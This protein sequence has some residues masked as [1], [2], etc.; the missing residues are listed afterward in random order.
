M[1]KDQ[2]AHMLAKF[3]YTQNFDCVD[4]PTLD[5]YFNKILAQSDPNEMQFPWSP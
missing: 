3:T 2:H 1:L 4:Q 5:L